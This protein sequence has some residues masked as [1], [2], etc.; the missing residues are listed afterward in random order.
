MTKKTF[1]V[2]ATDS[3]RYHMRVEAEDA[4]EAKDIAENAPRCEW[5]CSGPDMILEIFEVEEIEP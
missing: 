5:A 3:H 1:C 2:H 4:D